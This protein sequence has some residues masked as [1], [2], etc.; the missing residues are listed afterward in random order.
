[1][2]GGFAKDGAVRTASYG[3]LS[4][5]FKRL[6]A[7]ASLALL[8]TSPVVSADE[9]VT[10]KSIMQDLRDNLVDMGDG[11]LGNDLELV[12]RGALAIAEH[13]KIPP[14]QVQ[15]VAEELGREMQA[16]K[17]LDLLVHDLALEVHAAAKALDRP[18]AIAGYQRMIEGC[19]ACHEAYK[20]R[21]AAVL[22]NAAAD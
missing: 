17:Q 2:A 9:P 14:E 11:L 18:A 10:L 16:F 1:M 4:M 21:V 19:F 15:L 20:D 22:A 7:L 13:P 8:M 12:A 5:T 6:F 3:E